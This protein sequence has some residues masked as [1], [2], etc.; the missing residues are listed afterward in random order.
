MPTIRLR[1]RALDAGEAR[2]SMAR[3]ATALYLAGATMVLA[4]L[5]LPPTPA[6]L[7]P[8]RAHRL[9]FGTDFPNIPYAYVR[10]LRALAGLDFGAPWLRAVC[11]HNAARLLNL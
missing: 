2:V 4:D 1:P 3:A 6:A 7:F 8:E 11:H 10:Q 5:L 9:L